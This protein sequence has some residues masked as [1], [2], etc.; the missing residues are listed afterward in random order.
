MANRD[1]PSGFQPVAMLDGS[2]IP[3]RRFPVDGDTAVAIY[4]YDL[5]IAEA[6]GHVIAQ[7][8]GGANENA[9]LGSVVGLYDSNG[10][11]VGA[12]NSSVS[13]KYLPAS[14]AGFVDVALALPHQAI[15]KAQ[16]NASVLE[17]ARFAGAPHAVT[18]GVAATG[19]SRHEVG[20]VTTGQEFLIIIDKEDVP[21]NDWGT[22][23]DLLVTFGQS[24]WSPTVVGVAI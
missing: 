2:E 15:F 5:V 7:N 24:F 14:T 20:T 4:K 13:E 6:D 23:V 12:P 10:V 22:D 16:A 19:I 17:T 1:N 9:C 3:V 8:T 18:A 11:P 21:G